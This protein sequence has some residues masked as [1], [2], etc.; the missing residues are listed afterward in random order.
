MRE[1]ETIKVTVVREGQDDYLEFDVERRA[2]E[3]PTVNYE[4]MDGKIGYIEITEF[5]SVTEAQFI[6][7]LENLNSQGMEKLVIDLRN[8]LGGGA[9]DHLQYAEPAASGGTDCLYRG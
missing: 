2:I 5:D 3:V 1:G 9:S 7:A 6:S 4:M 8:N